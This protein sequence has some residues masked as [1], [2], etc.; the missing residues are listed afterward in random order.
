[1]RRSP[2]VHR[3][4]TA[5]IAIAR[6]AS[7]TSITFRRLQRS[8]YTPAGSPRTAYA[9]YV[10]AAITPTSSAEACSSSTATS[11]SATVVTAV[12]SCETDWPNQSRRKFAHSAL[13]AA[14][15]TRCER[16]SARSR[17]ALRRARPRPPSLSRP[18][19]R[20]RSRAPH[21]DRESSG[22]RRYGSTR[23][24]RSPSARAPRA[25]RRRGSC[26]GG[27]GFGRRDAGRERRPAP[28]HRHLRPHAHLRRDPLADH[29]HLLD[30]TLGPLRIVRPHRLE[31]PPLVER[32]LTRIC[33]AET[34]R[35]PL[36]AL[37]E[38]AVARQ[39]R[40]ERVSER[41]LRRQ[42]GALD[43]A[44]VQLADDVLGVD[45]EHVQAPQ[46]HHRPEREGV[47]LSSPLLEPLVLRDGRGVRQAL[48]E[49]DLRIEHP[50]RGRL[51]SRELIVGDLR[52]H[53]VD[54]GL[55][56]VLHVP[57]A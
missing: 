19:R 30:P 3:T 15:I 28:L 1:M 39:Q 50:L 20:T 13:S 25:A 10:A 11:G 33:R 43:I 9:A 57:I 31:R 4:G 53:L 23:T 54:L 56:P 21:P 48:E 18:G 8:T 24:P 35:E 38:L 32:K 52:E 51:V 37:A 47:E 12:P 5:P 7:V 40:V 41:D 14:S 16:R 42:D 29:Q 22:R 44:G 27:S 46:R 2:A 26:R 45:V 17:R 49:R 55:Q 6:P 34:A 36:R